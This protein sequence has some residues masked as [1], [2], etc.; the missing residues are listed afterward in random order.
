[1]VN[2]DSKLYINTLVV[3]IQ[4]QNIIILFLNLLFIILN[5]HKNTL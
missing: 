1:M 3:G 2:F 5:I 4:T